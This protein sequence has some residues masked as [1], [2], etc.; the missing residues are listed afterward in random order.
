MTV[1][2]L[3]G[4]YYD[5]RKEDY[6]TKKT[7]V[8]PQNIDTPIWNAFLSR[9]TGNDVDLQKYLQRMAGYCLTGHTIEH[10]LF[11]LY[12]TGA[13][14]KGVFINTLVEIWGDYAAVAPMTTFMA[15]HN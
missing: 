10:V 9:I 14:G 11:F 13:N 15:S 8:A 12:G 1:N 5:A 7:S 2:L 4:E 6:I 3:T